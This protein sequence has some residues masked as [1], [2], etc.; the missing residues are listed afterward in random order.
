[1][2]ENV[3]TLADDGLSLELVDADGGRGVAYLHISEGQLVVNAQDGANLVVVR[4]DPPAVRLLKSF[5]A[6]L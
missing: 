3:S 5:A 4:T 2:A 6:A 1:M